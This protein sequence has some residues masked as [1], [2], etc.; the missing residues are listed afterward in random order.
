MD[1]LETVPST[2]KL[3]HIRPKPFT[4]I[5]LLVVITIIMILSSMLIPALHTARAKARHAR[6]AAHSAGTRSTD[7]LEL[8]YDFKED[9]ANSADVTNKAGG[10]G[11]E[12]FFIDD[13]H[14]TTNGGMVVRK[15]QGRWIGKGGLYFTG[16]SGVS[17]PNFRWAKRYKSDQYPVTVMFWVKVMSGPPNNTMFQVNGSGGRFQCHVPWGGTIY[18]DYFNG[19]CCP[20]GRVST[21][22]GNYLDD[23][24]HVTFVSDGNGGNFRGIYLNGKL[25]ASTTGT[26]SSTGPSQDCKGFYMGGG[27]KGNIDEFAMWRRVMPPDEISAHYQNGAP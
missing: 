6:W 25:A 14:G 27:Y 10:A 5:E 22:F 20:T 9:D 11:I 12:A 15:D 21:G 19:S 2:Q 17:T 8:Y 18:W 3:L 13:G 24:T 7:M 4:L 1:N 23:W 26:A 16:S